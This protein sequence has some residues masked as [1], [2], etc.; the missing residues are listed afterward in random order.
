MIW[1]II[2]TILVGTLSWTIGMR[3]GRL[4]LRKG[5][6]ANDLFAG[7]KRFVFVVLALYLG[8][9]VLAI[10]LPQWQGLPLQWR[11]YGMQ[12]S[13]T[14][15]RVLLLGV[16]GVGYAIC[17][18]TARYQ[19][20]YLMIVGVLGLIC[21]TGVE[22]YFLSPIYGQLYN[23]LRPNG[24]YQQSGDS[25]CA[26]AAL[27]TLFQRWH[28]PQVTES[29]AAQY[30]GTSRM[31]T[32]MPQILQAVHKLNMDGVELA[33][34]WEQM[35]RINRPGVLAVWQFADGRKLPHAVAL[36]AMTNDRAVVADPASGK[37]VDLSR[38]EFDQTWRQEYLPVFRPADDEISIAQARKYLKSLGYQTDD[39]VVAIRSFQTDM[40]MQ[41]T[42]Q[43][44]SQ[45]VLLLTGQFIKDAPTLDEK[46]FA[47]DVLRRMNC[48]DNP[49]A[50][51]W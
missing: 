49:Q 48:L 47:Q 17:W 13:W 50:C 45:T 8:L 28:M 39:T 15:I 9:V 32:S 10:N 16:C 21:F 6:T 12:V 25:S 38:S 29:L 26:P 3:L 42:G 30:A 2:A 1:E 22:S 19:I 5:A 34:T 36:M 46:Q 31:G 24:V 18:K 40:G 35:R 14:I 44:D 33:P 43:L 4:M 7:K 23:N 27:A 37:Y 11:V 41:A 20:G 51:P